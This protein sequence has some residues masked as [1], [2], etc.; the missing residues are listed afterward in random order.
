VVDR[1]F[2]ARS[3]CIC[4][5]PPLF[6]QLIRIADDRQSKEWAEFLN[7][8]GQKSADFRKIRDEIDAETVSLCVTNKSVIKRP[9]NLNFYSPNV[10][11][12]TLV[13]LPGLTKDYG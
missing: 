7:D 8:P 2:R 3:A 4:K 9:I 13:D 5:R 6:L 1:D 12:L 10:L 11:N